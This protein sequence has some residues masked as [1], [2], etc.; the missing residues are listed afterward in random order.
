MELG[1]PWNLGESEKQETSSA[2]RQQIFSLTHST[3]Q[4]LHDN[5][6]LKHVA[7]KNK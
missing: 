6:A 5:K 1:P 4:T 2:R 3:A 7:P